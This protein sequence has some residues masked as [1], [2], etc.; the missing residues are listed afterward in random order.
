MP[1]P[2]TFL[3]V[4][5]SV[6]ILA[7]NCRIVQK[8]N[9]AGVIRPKTISYNWTNQALPGLSHTQHTA[10]GHVLYVRTYV[11]IC[12]YVHAMHLFKDTQVARNEHRRFPINATVLHVMCHESQVTCH[13]S[14]QDQQGKHQTEHTKH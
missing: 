7:S 14:C 9:I 13:M 4:V 5:M 2:C 1:K 10:A 12:T 8:R 3:H 11:C 6:H